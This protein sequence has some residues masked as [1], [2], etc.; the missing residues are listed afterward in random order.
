MIA[1]MTRK[2]LGEFGEP[3]QVI[4]V[5]SWGILLCCILLTV[6]PSLPSNNTR[7]LS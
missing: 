3:L 6:R 1:G 7:K 4:S 5:K 2:T